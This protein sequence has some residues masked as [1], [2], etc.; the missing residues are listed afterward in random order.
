MDIKKIEEND[1][2]FL[3]LD[4]A[5][6]AIIRR[7]QARLVNSGHDVTVEQ[8]MILLLLWLQD[9]VSQQYIAD[10]IGKDKGTISPQIDGLERRGLV[11]RKTGEQDRRQKLIFLTPVGR[12]LQ[13]ELIPIGIENMVEAQAGID[14]QALAACKQVLRDLCANLSRPL[15]AD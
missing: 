1:V 11:T 8:W 6:R 4:Q 13:D 12:D 2:L 7:M 15:H 9:G 3:L 10:F 14:P 5:G